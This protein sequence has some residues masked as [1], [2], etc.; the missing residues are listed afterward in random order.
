M[1]KHRD[2]PDRADVASS[3]PE[4]SP[5]PR[6]EKSLNVMDPDIGGKGLYRCTLQD[7]VNEAREFSRKCEFT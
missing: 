1:S 3:S 5:L 7:C 4:G 2:T 6:M